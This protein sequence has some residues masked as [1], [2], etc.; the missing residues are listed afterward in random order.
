MLESPANPGRFTGRRAL[1]PIGVPEIALTP[2]TVRRFRSHF[3]DRV[4]VSTR[5]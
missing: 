2:Q 3:G 4:A 5:G 1:V